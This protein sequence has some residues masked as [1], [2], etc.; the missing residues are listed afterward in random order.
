MEARGWGCE[1]E[2]VG[3]GV[4][5]PGRLG[6]GGVLVLRPMGEHASP[7]TLPL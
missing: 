2:V 6:R 3:Q 1:L 4:R 5:V 7:L